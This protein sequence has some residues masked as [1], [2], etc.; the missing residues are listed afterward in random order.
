MSSGSFCRVMA[1]SLLVGGPFLGA[2]WAENRDEARLPEGSDITYQWSYSCPKRMACGFSCP[3]TGTANHATK[4]N[5]YLGK[6]PVAT[7]QA[8]LVLFYSYST[9]YV[10]RGSGFSMDSGLG[11]LACQ[12]SG[13]TLDYFG[14]PKSDFKY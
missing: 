5:V 14:P 8:V 9:R 7:D 2:S 11:T 10:P 12:V 4:L 6:M 3:G 1:F 13:M